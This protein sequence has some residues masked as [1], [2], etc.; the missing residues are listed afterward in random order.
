[1]INHQAKESNE[2][3]NISEI[4]T[5][6]MEKKSLMKLRDDVATLSQKSQGGSFYSQKSVAELAGF[7]F[8]G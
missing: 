8:I 5:N 4:V 1:M 6:L 7:L 2:S 3:A